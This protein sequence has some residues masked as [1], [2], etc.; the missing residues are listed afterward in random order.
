MP[1]P[2]RTFLAECFLPGVHA[3]DVEA[4]GARARAVADELRAAGTPVEYLGALL[5][6]QDEVVFHAFRAGTLGDALEAS[7]R[8]GLPFERVVESVEVA[9]AVGAFWSPAAAS[10]AATGKEMA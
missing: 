2:L 6:E 1:D 4:A 8:A 3:S 9:T 5:V 7:R 10:S